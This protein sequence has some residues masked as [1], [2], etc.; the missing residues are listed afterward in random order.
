MKKNTSGP[1]RDG[2]RRLRVPNS[3]SVALVSGM[4]ATGSCGGGA[5]STLDGAKPDVQVEMVDAAAPSEASPEQPAD[6][7]PDQASDSAADTMAV[8]DAPMEMGPA[9]PDAAMDRPDA[10]SPADV[11]VDFPLT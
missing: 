9:T 7:A 3:L 6:S 5:T 1:G 11:R 8:M 10:S 4:L 2:L